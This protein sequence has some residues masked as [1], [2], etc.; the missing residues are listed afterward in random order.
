MSE[1]KSCPIKEVYERF[2]HLDQLLSDATWCNAGESSL[3]WDT[4]H[5]L[6]IAIKS[7]ITRPQTEESEVLKTAII[8]QREVKREDVLPYNIINK[9]VDVLSLETCERVAKVIVKYRRREG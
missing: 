8:I 6:W 9:S 7:Y 4:C 3:S 1:L 2:K 5:E